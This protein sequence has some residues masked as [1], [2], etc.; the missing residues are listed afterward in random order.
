MSLYLIKKNPC[1]YRITTSQMALNF[2]TILI[3]D[4][5]EIFSNYFS[6]IVLMDFFYA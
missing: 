2:K 1:N 5:F 6:S 4:D 3:T